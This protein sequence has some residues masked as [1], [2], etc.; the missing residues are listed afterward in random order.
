[1]LT[2]VVARVPG[3]APG[4]WLLFSR[5]RP[6]VFAFPPVSWRY[7]SDPLF[8][9]LGQAGL[10]FPEVLWERM[11]SDVEQLLPI[12]KLPTLSCSVAKTISSARAA[13]GLTQKQLATK[14]SLEIFLYEKKNRKERNRRDRVATD[15]SDKLER[16]FEAI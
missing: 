14:I 13:K 12:E 9:E 4:N 15:L 10:M 3:C 2:C 16:A 11:R 1:M 7:D 8:F 6:F 5:F